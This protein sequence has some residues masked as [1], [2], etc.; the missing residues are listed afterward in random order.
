MAQIGGGISAESDY[1]WHGYSLS[2]GHPT[3][4]AR[5]SYD[6]A[7]GVYVNASATA[8]LRR[9]EA[10]YLGF[11]ASGGYSVWLAPKLALDIGG[12][13]AEFRPAYPSGP[14]YNYTQFYV[15]VSH[16]PVQLRLSYSPDYFFKDWHTLYA[17]AETTLKLTETLRLNGHAGVLTILSRPVSTFGSGKAR[18]D[19][20]VGISQSLG[21]FEVHAN[22]SGGSPSRQRYEGYAHDLTAFTFGASLNF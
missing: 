7:S 19:W 12:E 2:A 9:G 1:R 16:D 8:Q 5:L 10:R 13:H 14:R 4:S 17:E 6:H 3:A 21:D 11:Q 15:G 18:Y 22:L 20:R